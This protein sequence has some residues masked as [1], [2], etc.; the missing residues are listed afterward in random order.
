MSHVGHMGH[1]GHATY[2]G[3]IPKEACVV[4]R[5]R[6]DARVLRPG[7]AAAGLWPDPGLEF[8]STLGRAEDDTPRSV[9]E[10]SP[11]RDRI[12]TAGE[13]TSSSP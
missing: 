12:A 2:V 1:V 11:C 10:R 7:A 9:R 5:G 6:Q 13:L 3:L 8:T 4:P